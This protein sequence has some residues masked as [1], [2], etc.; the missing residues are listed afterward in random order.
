MRLSTFEEFDAE[1]QRLR[2]E[3]QQL[4][5]ENERLRSE[6]G[7]LRSENADLKT[8]VAE[9]QRPP[10]PAT[11]QQAGSRRRELDGVIDAVLPGILLI[12]DSVSVMERDPISCEAV[13]RDLRTLRWEQPALPVGAKPVQGAPPWLESHFRTGQ[14]DDGR[15]YFRKRDGRWIALVSFKARQDRDVEYLKGN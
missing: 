4:R 12:R 2:D 8:R 9:L 13:L 10:Q 3:N 6:T 7:Q 5:D 14:K 11:S 15:L 1:N